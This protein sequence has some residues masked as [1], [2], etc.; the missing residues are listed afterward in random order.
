MHVWSF[1]ISG[2]S[3]PRLLALFVLGK[4]I[5]DRRP[6]VAQ[7]AADRLRRASDSHGCLRS[8]SKAQI[9]RAPERGIPSDWEDLKA[10]S[11]RIGSA[12]SDGA[13]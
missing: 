6:T 8:F 11:T 7:F 3:D 1:A 12:Q 9:E 2:I 4:A 13:T 10:T 5:I